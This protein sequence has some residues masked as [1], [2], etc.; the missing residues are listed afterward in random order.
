MGTHPPESYTR[1][2]NVTAKLMLV[3]KL[4]Q[5]KVNLVNFLFYFLCIFPVKLMFAILL[6]SNTNTELKIICKLFIEG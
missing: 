5:F 1:M 4:N 2:R 6:T 3:S